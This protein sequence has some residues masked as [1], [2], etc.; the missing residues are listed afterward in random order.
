MSLHSFFRSKRKGDGDIVDD[1]GRNKKPKPPTRKNPSSIVSWNCENLISRIK[2]D[3]PA[4]EKFLK[5]HD[6]DVLCLQECKLAAKCRDK[7]AKRYDGAVRY[8]HIIA[9][10]T[11]QQ[12]ED[13]CMIQR[14][15]ERGILSSYKAYWSLADWKY[16]GTACFVKKDIDVVRIRHSVPGSTRKGHHMDGRVILLEFESMLL[17]NT[18]APNNGKTEIKW[19]QR[20]AWDEELLNCFKVHGMMSQGK[21]SK[22]GS[23]DDQEGAPFKPIVWVGDLN[24]AV[25]DDDVSDTHFF[26]TAKSL[27]GNG[28]KQPP[29]PKDE[30]LRGYPGFTI[31]EQTRFQ[32]ICKAGLGLVDT[33]RMFVP[34]G[35]EK[36]DQESEYTWRGSA[37]VNS[38]FS[39]LYGKG[40]RLDYA[41]VQTPL[42]THVKS[43]AILGRGKDRDGFLGSDHAPIEL[44]LQ[45]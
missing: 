27:Y 42:A 25:M 11:K 13:F 6:P 19:T 38:S 2:K 30:K 17:L 3:L 12:N 21:G 36:I 29:V 4:L 40:M 9:Q 23:G 16:A 10:E 32:N 41:L 34:Y 7:N 35:S 37:P 43:S 31:C 8:R 5:D 24:V 15:L 45:F 18:Y 44:V 26:R 39:S 22:G 14:L 20:S 1:S 28:P 33:Y